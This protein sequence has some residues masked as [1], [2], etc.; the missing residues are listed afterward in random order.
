RCGERSFRGSL[1]RGHQPVRDFPPAV[2]RLKKRI[3]G[4]NRSPP[5]GR[6]GH[7]GFIDRRQELEGGLRTVA[8]G[9]RTPAGPPIRGESGQL[10]SVRTLRSLGDGPEL[11][12]EGFVHFR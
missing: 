10:R 4:A 5:N 7:G 11:L 1:G 6:A 2:K 12:N 8:G 3:S 9:V